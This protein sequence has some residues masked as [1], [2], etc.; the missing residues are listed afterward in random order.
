METFT[1]IIPVELEDGTI[2]NIQ[3][4][5]IGEQP[6]SFESHP[7]KEATAAIKSIS[8][9]IAQTLKEINQSV[10]PD[11]ISITF[12]LEIAIE[13][14]HLTT[15]IAKGSTTANLEITMEWGK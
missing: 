12:G 13:S 2:I 7:F 3:A 14:G 8:N 6:V 1:E 15:L 10:S 5:P 9:E 4:T 11:K